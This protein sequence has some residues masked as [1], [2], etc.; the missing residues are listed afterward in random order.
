VV[1][2]GAVDVAAE[3][4][5]LGVDELAYFVELGLQLHQAGVVDHVLLHLLVLARPHCLQP[6]QPHPRHPQRFLAGLPPPE[7]LARVTLVLRLALAAQLPVVVASR[8]TADGH[9]LRPVLSASVPPLL[10][11][12]Y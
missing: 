2:V 5:E 9:Y 4:V 6:G 8:R 7:V 3:G 11:L 10:R 1:G 12:H